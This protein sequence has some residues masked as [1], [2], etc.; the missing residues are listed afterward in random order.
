[1]AGIFEHFF[2]LLPHFG[3]FLGG[4]FGILESLLD[5]IAPLL[6]KFEHRA[7]GIPAQNK[8]QDEEVHRLCQKKFPINAKIC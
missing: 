2:L 6:Q 4:R 8:K 3:K 7:I 1:M 5:A